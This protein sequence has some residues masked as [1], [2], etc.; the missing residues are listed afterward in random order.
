MRDAASRRAA[1]II[2][3]MLAVVL[4][5]AMHFLAPDKIE[6]PRHF[7]RARTLNLQEAA[8]SFA[9]ET[10]SRPYT[11]SRKATPPSVGAAVR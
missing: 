10:L 9:P 2:A 11:S 7:G 8:A 6:S 1:S 4:A 3:A 5:V